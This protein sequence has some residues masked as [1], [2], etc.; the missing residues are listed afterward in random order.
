MKNKIE[1]FSSEHLKNFLCNLKRCF[2]INFRDNQEKEILF[3]QKKFSLIFIEEKDVVLINCLNKISKNKNLLVVCKEHSV[4]EKLCFVKNNT[5]VAPISINKLI[6]VINSSINFTKHNFGNIEL[7][8]F[9]I[10]NIETNLIINLTEIENHILLKLFKEE[11]VHKSKLERD[12]LEIKEDINTSSIE[13]H[14]NRIRKKLNKIESNVTIV[15][16][17]KSVNLE[18]S[19]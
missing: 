7:K 11:S 2:D 6:N 5:L 17:D 12:V 15:S 10:K 8:N 9:I 19:I 16:K 14:L 1:I 3:D 4:Y 18:F 13:S